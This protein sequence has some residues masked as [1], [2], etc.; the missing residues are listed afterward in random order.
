MICEWFSV[1]SE[2]DIPNWITIIIELGIGGFVAGLF[3]WKQKKQGDKIESVVDKM[4]QQQTSISNLISEI[5]ILEEKQN[6]YIDQQTQ[7]QIKSV[8]YAFFSIYTD[9]SLIRSNLSIIK[10]IREK[11]PDLKDQNEQTYMKDIK[12]E[13]QEI[14]F[15]LN[16]FG[17]SITKDIIWDI[18]MVVRNATDVERSMKRLEEIIEMTKNTIGKIEKF[19]PENQKD[20]TPPHKENKRE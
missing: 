8:E 13:V 5:K 9:L 6:K 3:F 7:I 2:C 18:M 11:H 15:I 20:G 4:Q 14:E 17:T 16:S 1:L 19:V 12:Q 10:G